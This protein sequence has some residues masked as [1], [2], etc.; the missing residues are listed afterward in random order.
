MKYFNVFYMP[1]FHLWACISQL[2]SDITKTQCVLLLA[3]W[4]TV[5]ITRAEVFDH[6]A[7]R[8]PC[9]CKSLEHRDIMFRQWKQ[10]RV[11]TL[12]GRFYFGCLCLLVVFA[13]TW[14]V[15]KP[16]TT[17]IIKLQHAISDSSS[18][19]CDLRGILLF[20]LIKLT[21]VRNHLATTQNTLAIA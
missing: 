10:T 21:T 7:S 2:K 12:A 4:F 18:T 1:G 20:W 6:L 11:W 19:R 16:I 3:G 14:G 13:Y 17:L 8:V 5:V 9:T 15:I